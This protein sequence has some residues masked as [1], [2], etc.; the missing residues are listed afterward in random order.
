[1]CI[2]IILIT[3]LSLLASFLATVSGFG[4]GTLMTPLLLLFLPFSQ[5]VFLV[6]IIHWFHDI[7]KL[8]FFH[9]G[10]DW[11]LLIMFG[12]PMVI[13]SFFGALFVGIN[14]ELLSALLGLLLI[15]YVIFLY[16]KPSFKMAYTPS[17]TIIGGGLSGFFAGIFGVRGEIH[18]AFLSSYNLSK[19][20]YLSTIAAISLLADSTRTLMY[21]FWEGIRLSPNIAWGFLFFIPA[22]LIGAWFGKMMIDRIPQDKFRTLVALFLLVAGIWFVVKPIFVLL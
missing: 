1:M 6:C 22:S 15:S 9:Y 8:F 16:I 14:Q 4:L 11:R 2:V 3:V 5:T 13:G 21:W 18:S 17:N 7:W 19:A 12:A 10:I 20:T